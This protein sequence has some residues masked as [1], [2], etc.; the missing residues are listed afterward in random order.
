MYIATSAFPAAPIRL[1]FA[2]AIALAPIGSAR[3]QSTGP[4]EGLEGSWAGAGAITLS[5]GATGRL[6]CEAT[7]V[8][9]GGGDTLR[10]TLL[11]KSDRDSFNLR[12]ELENHNGAIVGSW[13]ELSRR[14]QGGI[15]GR[16][17][18]GL[19]EVTVRGQGFSA[20]AT[21]TTRGAQQTFNIR[22]QSG[23]VLQGL[24][25]AS[26]RAVR[27]L[28]LRRRAAPHPSCSA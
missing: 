6:K 16:G 22:A 11:C 24:G 12:T 8:V 17:A 1:V 18:K 28:V 25:D 26:A 7:Y 27:G 14:V 4:F 2:A 23:D 5:S 10:Q 9:G 15:S 20:S 13:S 3:A 21:I 19:I